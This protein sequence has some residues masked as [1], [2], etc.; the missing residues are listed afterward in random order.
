MHEVSIALSLLDIA[1]GH[2]ERE[3]YKSIESI[4][5]RIGKASGIMSEALLFAFDA[6]KIGTIAEKARLFIEEVPVGGF[7]SN[8]KQSFVVEESFVLCCPNCGEASFNL[9]T[10]RELDIYEME[11]TDES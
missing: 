9:E 4:R 5:V 6:V 8:C 1:R 3:G 2:C 11:V 7:C 10:G